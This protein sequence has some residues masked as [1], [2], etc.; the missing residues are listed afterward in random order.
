[1]AIEAYLDDFDPNATFDSPCAGQYHCCIVKVQEGGGK[2]GEMIVDYEILAGKPADQTGKVFRDYFHVTAK[3]MG[4]IHQLAIASQLVTVD[5]LNDMKSRGVA[6]SYDFDG[7]NGKNRQV[8]LDLYE[9]EYQGKTKVK[10]GFGIYRPD[11]PKC[12][13]WVKD[14]GLFEAG[15]FKAT[16]KSQASTQ[17]AS[18]EDDLLAGV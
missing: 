10:C 5:Q 11:D 7:L 14:M 6:P 1:M 18:A 4:R 15:G 2:R 12:E 3:A 8:M 16:A 13:K 9:E 17:A